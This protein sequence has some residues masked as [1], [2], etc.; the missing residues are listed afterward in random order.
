MNTITLKEFK[1]LPVRNGIRFCPANTSYHNITDFQSCSFGS[2]CSFKKGSEFGKFNS[3]GRYCSF[4][5]GTKFDDKCSFGANCYFEDNCK[6]GTSNDFGINT[7]FGKNCKFGNDYAFKG[8]CIF[9]ERYLSTKNELPFIS[10]NGLGFRKGNRLIVY[11]FE[12][13]VYV[14]DRNFFGTAAEYVKRD[15]AFNFCIEYVKLAAK[16]IEYYNNQ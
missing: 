13:G 8:D 3:F 2:E 14:R 4:D 12:K 6:F 11:N 9:E 7:T 1:E 5:I 15:N 10:I 16:K